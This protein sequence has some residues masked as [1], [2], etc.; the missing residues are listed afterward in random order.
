[1]LPLSLGFEWD[2]VEIV[3][4]LA[5]LSTLDPAWLCLRFCFVLVG[6]PYIAPVCSR[7]TQIVT[8]HNLTT[9][10][11]CATLLVQDSCYWRS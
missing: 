4:F 9:L 8:L 1:M 5:E 6:S 11:L 10:P 2:A 3:T 7:Q